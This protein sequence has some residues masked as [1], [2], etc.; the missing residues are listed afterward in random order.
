MNFKFGARNG[1]LVIFGTLAC[2]LLLFSWDLNAA[3]YKY[4]DK[5]GRIYYVDDLSK[6]PSEYQDQVQVYKEKYDYLPQISLD[7]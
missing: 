7:H 3:F 1:F 4:V 6:V 2:M 5:E